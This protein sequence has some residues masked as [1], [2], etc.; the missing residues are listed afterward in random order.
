MPKLMLTDE[1]A[2]VLIYEMGDGDHPDFNDDDNIYDYH[3]RLLKSK[4]LEL[5]RGRAPKKKQQI[6]TVWDAIVASSK[7]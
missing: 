4:L 5:I 7:S 3:R 1:E 2:A 6:K